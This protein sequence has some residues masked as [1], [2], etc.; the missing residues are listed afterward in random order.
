[1]NAGRIDQDDLRVFAVQNS[2]DA[3]AGGL[4]LRRNDGDF[5]ADQRVYERGFARV[6]AADDGDES[7]FERHAARL[8]A[9]LSRASRCFRA[10]V[11]GI[12]SETI[13]TRSSRVR[14]PSNSAKKMDC[15]RPRASRP[16]SIHTVSD[17]PISAVLMCESEF[18]SA[19]V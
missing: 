16:F 15:Q 2:L 7:G 11:S 17:E 14:G 13:L 12:Q 1:M 19:C 18:P 4:R 9:R 10:G 5:A 6:G 8:Y 3:I